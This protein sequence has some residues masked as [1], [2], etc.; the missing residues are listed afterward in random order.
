[1]SCM[2]HIGINSFLII[3]TNFGIKKLEYS[4]QVVNKFHSVMLNWISFLCNADEFYLGR[5]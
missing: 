5:S 4:T 3:T 1:M 2:C